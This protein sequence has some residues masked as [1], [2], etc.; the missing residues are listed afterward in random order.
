MKHIC[1]DNNICIY[2]RTYT[3][4]HILILLYVH[5]YAVKADLRVY[6]TLMSGY[7][8]HTQ[9]HTYNAQRNI[10]INKHTHDHVGIH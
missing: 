9:D 5:K 1:I 4:L 6:K 3:Y 8:M 7:Y 2:R 10:H